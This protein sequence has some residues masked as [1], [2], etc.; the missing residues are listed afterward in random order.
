MVEDSEEEIETI[1][2]CVS[3]LKGTAATLS[4]IAESNHIRLR[5]LCIDLSDGINEILERNG[6]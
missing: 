1:S 6:L 3:T 2:E 5:P 4:S